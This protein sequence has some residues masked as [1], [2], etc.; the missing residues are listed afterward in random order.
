VHLLEVHQAVQAGLVA[1]MG[2]GHVLEQ[3]RHEGNQRRLQLAH[4]HSVRPVVA[5]GVDQGLELLEDLPELRRNLFPGLLQ[6]GHRHVGQ[7]HYHSEEG[8]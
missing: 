2:E 8:V 4:E 5:T 7:T 6:P 1:L 3:E